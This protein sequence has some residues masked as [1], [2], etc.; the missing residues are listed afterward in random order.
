MATGQ[1]SEPKRLTFPT[2]FRK[3]LPAPGYKLS[4]LNEFRLKSES[5]EVMIF[6]KI[7]IQT[8]GDNTC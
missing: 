3:S 8:H 4:I 7:I 1:S 2:H 6:Y 5:N